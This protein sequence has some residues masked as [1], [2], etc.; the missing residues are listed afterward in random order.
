VR[1]FFIKFEILI[2]PISELAIIVLMM[3]VRDKLFID[4]TFVSS[5][6]EET[7]EVTYDTV[8]NPPIIREVHAGVTKTPGVGPTASSCRGTYEVLSYCYA[9]YS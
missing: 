3:L 1:I 8:S 7:P 6:A 2:F 9:Q 5:H 4:I